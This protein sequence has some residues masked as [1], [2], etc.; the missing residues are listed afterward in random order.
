LAREKQEVLSAM[1]GLSANQPGFQYPT[2]F[3]RARSLDYGSREPFCNSLPAMVKKP[4]EFHAARIVF[5]T[6]NYAILLVERAMFLRFRKCRQVE[7]HGL[8]IMTAVAE[9]SL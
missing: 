1:P 7:H 2:P 5:P 8:G 4:D 6:K 3:H 9:A